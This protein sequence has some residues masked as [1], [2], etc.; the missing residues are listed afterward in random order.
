MTAELDPA[1][2]VEVRLGNAAA[3]EPHQVRSWDQETGEWSEWVDQDDF[4]TRIRGRPGAREIVKRIN[5]LIKAAKA[6]SAP[7]PIAA[8]DFTLAEKVD[9]LRSYLQQHPATRLMDLEL[10]RDAERG[11]LYILAKKLLERGE[12]LE[13]PKTRALTFRGQ[14]PAAAGVTSVRILEDLPAIRDSDENDRLLIKREFEWVPDNIARALIRKGAAEEAWHSVPITYDAAVAMPE[15]STGQEMVSSGPAEEIAIR[16]LDDVPDFAGPRGKVYSMKK[17]DLLRLPASVARALIRRGVA[18]EVP[19]PGPAPEDVPTAAPEASLVKEP[20]RSDLNDAA[21]VEDGAQRIDPSQPS[22]PMETLPAQPAEPAPGAKVS[23][24]PVN[25]LISEGESINRLLKISRE[26]GEDAAIAAKREEEAP[27]V[28]IQERRANEEREADDEILRSGGWWNIVDGAIDEFLAGE[29]MLRK[30]IVYSALSAGLSDG[31]L[32][33]MAIGD[34]QVGKS[35]ALRSIGSRLFPGIFIDVASMSGKALFY[36]AK[37]ANN[38]RYYDGKILLIDELADQ[39]DTTLDFMKAGM[40]PGAKKLT[41]MTVDEHRKFSHQELEGLPIFWST[42]AEVLEDAEGQI[43]NRPFVV[44][45]DESTE[46]TQKIM[47]FQRDAA[48]INLVK[49]IESKIPHAR[50][51][52]ER[53]LEEKDLTVYNL[54]AQHVRISE[55]DARA[56]NTLPMFFNLVAA[57]AYAHRFD[58][59]VIELPNGKRLLFANYQD[60]VEAAELWQWASGPKSTGLM[61]RHIELLKILPVFAGEITGGLDVDRIREIYCEQTGRKASHKSIRNYLAELS[62]KDKATYYEDEEG[63]HLYYSLGSSHTIPSASHLLVGIE[64]LE[65]NKLLDEALKSLKTASSHFP[66]ETQLRMSGLREELLGKRS[67]VPDGRL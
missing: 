33:L 40:S 64:S 43:M 13:H 23:T 11:P 61:N 57:V 32:H 9:R 27:R 18:A 54:F 38:P 8:E 14:A 49:V 48:S 62:S 21:G 45:P 5:E 39:S 63:R 2:S 31:R 66:T 47:G 67:T 19:T 52:L 44:N 4:I 56:R 25:P 46:Q 3:G 53:I 35:Y 10:H 1:S 58:R 36:A 22:L 7:A 24:P 51:L 60:N 59:P 6:S 15:A 17:E 42:S 41:N 65:G 34:S 50:R 26:Q 37:E 28:E 30:A 12:L 55:D 20:D 29:P 16:I